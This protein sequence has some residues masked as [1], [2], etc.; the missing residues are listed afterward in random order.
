M[1]GLGATVFFVG[2]V[3]P[4]TWFIVSSWKCLKVEAAN[5]QEMDEASLLAHE[6]VENEIMFEEAF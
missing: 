4:L 2:G 1:R 6:K 5:I 3:I